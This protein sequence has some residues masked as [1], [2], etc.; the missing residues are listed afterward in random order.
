M[1]DTETSRRAFRSDAL[2]VMSD[3]TAFKENDDGGFMG[4]EWWGLRVWLLLRAHDLEQ[5][6]TNLI[7]VSE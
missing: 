5:R 6:D 2:G 7:H 4:N 1:L 3:E